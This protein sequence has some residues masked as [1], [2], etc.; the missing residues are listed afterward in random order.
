MSVQLRKATIWLIVLTGVGYFLAYLR[1]AGVAALYGASPI[2]DAFFVG[3]FLPATLYTVVIIG[4]LVPALL[5]VL[6]S[7]TVQ[8]PRSEVQSLEL[9]DTDI[10]N[11]VV[12]AMSKWLLLVLLVIVGVGEI[13]APL[14]I[15]V[16]APG[17]DA[18]TAGMAALFLRAS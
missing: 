15:S 12:T 13:A 16:L 4:S 2:T 10:W 7:L 14:L 17:F 6:S 3:T 5:P 18:H 1:D 8:S 9:A 11:G